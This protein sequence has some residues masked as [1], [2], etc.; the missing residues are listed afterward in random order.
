MTVN[1]PLAHPHHTGLQ[2]DLP[3]FDTNK[4]GIKNMTITTTDPHNAT[5]KRVD[6]FDIR[7]QEDAHHVPEHRTLNKAYFLSCPN[8]NGYQIHG[9][10][11]ITPPVP[12]I[13]PAN[14]PPHYHDT[15]PIYEIGRSLKSG[16]LYAEVPTLPGD[17]KWF[18]R[19]TYVYSYTKKGL[20]DE[21]QLYLRKLNKK[22]SDMNHEGHDEHGGHDA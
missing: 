4:T 2:I 3:G 1:V 20:Y 15:H 17:E 9:D 6:N 22:A 8:E 19:K 10:E 5:N 13:P 18:G 16:R 7:V 11:T 12:P 14:Q 21:I